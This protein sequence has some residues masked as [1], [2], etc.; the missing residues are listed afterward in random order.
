MAAWGAESASWAPGWKRHPA[1]Y[2]STG[3]LA[4]F[5][6]SLKYTDYRMEFFGQIED[7][8]MG[9]VVRA[10]DKQNYYA[11]KF[12]VIEPGL[13]PIIAMVHY[14]VTNGKPG[15]QGADAAV[16]DGAQQPARPRGGGRAGQPLHR[17]RSKASSGIVD[18]RHAR[19][20]G[21]GFFS[22]AGEKA[23]LYWMKLSRRIRIGWAVSAPTSPATGK[24][25][26]AELWG[27]GLPSGHARAASGARRNAGHR[28]GRE[29]RRLD[30]FQRPAR[31]KTVKI[32]GAN[33]GF[34]STLEQ[35][36]RT[37]AVCRPASLRSPT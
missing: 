10:Q 25:E 37:D 15:P 36:S 3:E 27:P 28:A 16:G 8:S 31:A 33:H 20:G 22:D 7:K 1:G 14:G 4:L 30:R 21:V 29:R 13:R 34:H 17:P 9:W 24:Q 6:P 23:R 35:A 26:T 32:G 2:V 11:M 19:A 5:Q 18:G 12:T